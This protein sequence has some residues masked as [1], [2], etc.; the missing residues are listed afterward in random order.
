MNKTLMLLIR[1][2]NLMLGAD[3]PREVAGR[4]DC[5]REYIPE[6]HLTRFDQLLHRRRMAVAA[7]TATDFCGGC[8]LRQPVGY[9]HIIRRHQN[10]IAHCKFCGCFL[11]VEAGGKDDLRPE[12]LEFYPR[13]RSRI[14]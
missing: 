3:C 12:P 6:T 9:A 10:H 2:Q 7:L 4:I 13:N 1:L 8:L 14:L 5:L 11:Y